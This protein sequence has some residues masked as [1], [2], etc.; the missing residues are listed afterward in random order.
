MDNEFY[1][2]RFKKYYSI[3]NLCIIII[4]IMHHIMIIM[5]KMSVST[6][7]V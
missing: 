5:L 1:V 7:R 6:Y 3:Y 4:I 2:V